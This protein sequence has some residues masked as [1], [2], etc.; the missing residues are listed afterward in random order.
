[1]KNLKSL[2]KEELVKVA[3]MKGIK[4]SSK[5]TRIDII[6]KISALN[7]VIAEPYNVINKNGM[8]L[9]VF[10]EDSD[11]YICHTKN[12]VK[13]TLKKELVGTVFFK[14]DEI[15][16]S[17]KKDPASSVNKDT[18][19]VFVKEEK[20]KHR[21][22]LSISKGGNLVVMDNINHEVYEVGVSPIL[23]KALQPFFMVVAKKTMEENKNFKD[24]SLIQ[25][26][27]FKYFRK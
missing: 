20:G 19:N 22:V 15:P 2:K 13:T 21:F 8:V 24:M 7:D 3:E 9:T 16:E 23:K 14:E 25:R 12:G 4:V 11:N 1:M 27:V 17:F 26:F 10:G 18:G 6:Q 5:D